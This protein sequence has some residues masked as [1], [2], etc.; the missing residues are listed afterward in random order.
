MCLLIHTL[1][2]L[3]EPRRLPQTNRRMRHHRVL[4]RPMPM[5][6][7]RR[8]MHNVA[9]LKHMRLLTPRLHKARAHCHC[10]DLAVLVVMP[11]CAGAGCETH[12]VGHAVEVGGFVVGFG[13][14]DRIHVDG[15]GEGFCR[16]ARSRVGGMRALDQLH[17]A[18]VAVMLF[19]GFW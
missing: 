16:L 11:E 7:A 12:V 8:H 14:E 19:G 3:L 13:F 9:N 18:L 2:Y 6:L 1:L 10:E 4:P 5:H 17:G 15:A